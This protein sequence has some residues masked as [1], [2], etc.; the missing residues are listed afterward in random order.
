M[1]EL[2]VKDKHDDNDGKSSKSL[3]YFPPID[4]PQSGMVRK[5][6]T[7]FSIRFHSSSVDMVVFNARGSFW[8]LPLLWNVSTFGSTGSTDHHQKPNDD[9]HPSLLLHPRNTTW[10]S[11]RSIRE[12]SIMIRTSTTAV[13]I[14]IHSVMEPP[15][16]PAN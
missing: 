13:R 14:F 10:P 6:S 16:I 5:V 1:P 4:S 8:G 15:Q 11:W 2:L 3:L 7:T 9:A 12:R